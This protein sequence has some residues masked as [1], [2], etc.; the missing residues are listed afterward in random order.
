MGKPFSQKLYDKNDDAKFQVIDWLNSGD[1]DSGVNPDQYG[2]DVLG[3]YDDTEAMFEVEVKHNWKGPRFP[4]NE[5]HWPARKLKF[6]K[7]EGNVFFVM[8]NHERSH[9]LVAKATDVLASEIVVK[10]TK[11]TAS[12]EFIEVPKSKCRFFSFTPVEGG[13]TPKDIL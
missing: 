3:T 5:V 4:Y 13:L 9:A 11:Y 8:L 12:E 1:W 2:I 10:A 6:A 7:L